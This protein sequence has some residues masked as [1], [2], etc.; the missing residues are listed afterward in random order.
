MVRVNGYILIILT[1]S[2]T[3]GSMSIVSRLVTNRSSSHRVS[4]SNVSIST[5]I[6]SSFWDNDG[7]LFLI[8]LT[9]L[10]SFSDGKF[11]K[12]M[13]SFCFSS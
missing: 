13:L 7:F 3:F 4:V 2:W 9:T 10:S 11:C 6:S 8:I 12:F 5:S 1:L